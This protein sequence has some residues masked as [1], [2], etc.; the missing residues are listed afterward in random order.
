MW[1][2]TFLSAALAVV[3]GVAVVVGLELELQLQL[4]LRLRLS[5][6]L[7]EQFVG[8]LQE[9]SHNR[10]ERPFRAAYASGFEGALALVVVL[11][12]AR[13]FFGGQQPTP[14]YPITVVCSTRI[15]YS[16]RTS[17]GCPYGYLSTPIYF[18]AILL[19]CSPAPSSVISTTVPR[20]SK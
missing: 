11:L 20:I 14:H 17:P 19:M 10:E 1:S 8:K 12:G 4:L 18:F 16:T 13:E 5:L 9:C 6:G 3:V 7:P 15:L 2:R